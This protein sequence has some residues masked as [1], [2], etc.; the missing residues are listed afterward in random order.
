M[1]IGCVQIE[2]EERKRMD[3]GVSWE[4]PSGQKT[5]FYVNFRTDIHFSKGM[6]LESMR[7]K[8]WEREKSL[9]E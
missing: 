7:R 8:E 5:K 6:G 9:K 4:L 1:E 2:A 3:V